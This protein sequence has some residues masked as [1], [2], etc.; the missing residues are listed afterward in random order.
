[1]QDIEIVV[2]RPN[3]EHH[4]LG[5]IMGQGGDN[6]G[7]TLWGQT[8]LSCYDDSMHGIWGMS[9]K[10]HERAVVFNEKNLVRLWD[11]AYDGYVG[12]KD[13]T[14]VDWT[15]QDKL[16]HFKSATHDTSQN[17]KGPSLMVMAF[18]HDSGSQEYRNGFQ[19]NWPS[20]IVYH[21]NYDYTQ[22]PGNQ[23]D[24]NYTLSVDYDNVHVTNVKD[25]RVF[26]KPLYGAYRHYFHM[27]PNF[28]SLHAIRKPAGSSTV[29]N[30]TFYDSLA[31]QGSMRTFQDGHEVDS[32]QG[33]GH[34]GP[35][36]VG[37]AS[38][39]SGKGYKIQGA[40]VPHRMV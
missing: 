27:M 32:I 13:A 35:D 26:N 18:Q 20:P 17:Y 3:I 5:I 33:S 31:F 30:Q 39:R 19:R 14:S 38:I 22:P 16:D 15:D 36:W 12:G 29:D 11:V 7:N 4:M 28:S 8:E 34:H 40:P 37:A 1:L 9:Y 10:Y 25:M 24:G 23:H 2:V 6:L 21:D